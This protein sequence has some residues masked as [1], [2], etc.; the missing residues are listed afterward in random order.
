MSLDIKLRDNK[1][2]SKWC[3]RVEVVCG[4]VLRQ[5]PMRI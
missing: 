5:L 1:N 4:D 2:L 3:A